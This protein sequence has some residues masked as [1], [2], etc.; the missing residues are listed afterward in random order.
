MNAN[1][2]TLKTQRLVLTPVSVRHAPSLFP[3][4]S[5]A[6]LT[7]YLAWAPHASPDETVSV[8]RSLELAQLEGA[9]YHWTIFEDGTARGLIS[10]IDVRRRHRLWTFDRAEIAYWIDPDRQGRGI[11]TEATAAIVDAAFRRLDLH[12]LIVSHTSDNP[13]SG[14]IPQRL[15][16]RLVG[17]ERQFFK[18]NG[19]WHDMNHYEL[20]ADD[21]AA[22]GRS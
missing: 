18:K 19:V 1:D 14:R 4:M 17:T 3:L 6:R 10:L 2:L 9:G 22:E 8:L 15:G 11:A 5:D 20:L 13:A 21:W 7:T 16:F 12:R